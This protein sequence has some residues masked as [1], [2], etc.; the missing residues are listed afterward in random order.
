MTK[1]EFRGALCAALE[2]AGFTVTESVFREVCVVRGEPDMATV[3]TP[4]EWA[5][6][7]DHAA[8]IRRKVGNEVLLRDIRRQMQGPRRD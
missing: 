3:V 5:R 6:A 1:D 4:Q 7:T 8:L 2:A